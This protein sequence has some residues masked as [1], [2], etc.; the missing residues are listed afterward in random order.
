MTATETKPVRR[1]GLRAF[2]I[3]AFVVA[4]CV[5]CVFLLE[6]GVSLALFARDYATVGASRA[7][8]RPYTTHDTLLGWVNRPNFEAAKE[9]GD[10]T[11][12][13]TN[14]QGFRGTHALAPQA[15]SGV[16]RIA[17]SGDA[18]TLGV[19]VDDAHAWCALLERELTNVETMNMG[20][21]GYGV[22]QAALWYARDGI[23]LAPRV[24]L[25][26]LTENQFERSLGTSFGGRVKPAFALSGSRLV[27]QGV[28]VPMQTDEALRDAARSRLFD[29][30]RVVQWARRYPRF[31]P[32]Y[33]AATNVLDQWS[34]FD[35]ILREAAASDR[36]RGIVPVVVYLPTRRDLR[37]GRLDERRARIAET[38]RTNDMALIDLTAPLRTMR[39]DSQDLAFITKPLPGAAPGVSG[40]YSNLGHAWVARE[41]SARLR[42]LPS[43]GLAAGK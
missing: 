38:A 36:A 34:L 26:A 7:I 17:C 24:H 14:A 42:A 25:I 6:G 32:T 35:A 4:V 23:A 39:A 5:A 13:T 10:G 41:I 21:A 31:N 19:G 22:D 8:E 29:G 40:S 27:T 15:V 33:K 28:P 9:F 11:G 37:P 1:R 30:L 2:A 3:T 18:L 43:I 16:T 12:L 20:Q